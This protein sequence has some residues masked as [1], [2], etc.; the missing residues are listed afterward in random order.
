[1]TLLVVQTGIFGDG[2]FGGRP[3]SD[4]DGVL[5]DA[6]A[7]GY[8]GVE[9]MTNLLRK[10]ERLR[11]ACAARGLA[12]AAAHVF[13]WERDAPEVHRAIEVLETDRLILSCLPVKQPADL[14][15]VA[16]ELQ[17]V[18]AVAHSVG[19]SLLVHNHREEGLVLSDGRTTIEALAERLAPEDLGFVLDLHWAAVAGTLTRT[20]EAVGARCD[21]YHFKDGSLTE[22][23]NGR[24]YDL[25]EGE[26]DLPGAWQLI[27]G[28]PLTVAAAERSY[29]PTDQMAALRHDASYIRAL[30]TEAR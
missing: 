23:K 15:P 28:W 27:C 13:W 7:A 9:V 1:M 16:E 11:D 24:S 5:D 20:L 12:V 4:L 22:P 29:A 18:A 14:G 2:M 19:A 26:V 21:Y 8:D 3:E 25:G 17:R 30:L 10:P 6:R